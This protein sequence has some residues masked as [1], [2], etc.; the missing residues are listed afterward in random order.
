M[1]TEA[2]KLAKELRAQGKT[3]AEAAK[4]LTDRGYKTKT[5]KNYTANYLAV[6]LSKK[7]TKKV[8][9]SAKH[10]SK[11]PSAAT[12]APV[13]IQMPL[14]MYWASI[15]EKTGILQF[16]RINTPTGF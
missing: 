3:V 5:G 8:K 12:P 11:V 15:N 6:L 14:G 1:N 16:M 7:K 13:D 4:E 10:V 9:K 2:I